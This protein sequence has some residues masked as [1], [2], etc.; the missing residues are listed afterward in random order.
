MLRF[1]EN[2]QCWN[3]RMRSGIF[4]QNTFPLFSRLIMQ[5]KLKKMLS[6]NLNGSLLS[7]KIQKLNDCDM[8]LLFHFESPKSFKMD[9]D[10][11]FIHVDDSLWTVMPGNYMRMDSSKFTFNNLTFISGNQSIG[12]DGIISKQPHDELNI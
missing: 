12:L 3:C 9:F 11:T 5:P 1:A 4:F 7:I 2:L 6:R 10:S 8:D